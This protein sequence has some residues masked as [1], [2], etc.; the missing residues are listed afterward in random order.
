MR[1][2]KQQG[3]H[4]AHTASMW[5]AIGRWGKGREIRHVCGEERSPRVLANKRLVWYGGVV[6]TVG[7]DQHT[8]RYTALWTCINA[9]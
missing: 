1:Y 2:G 3:M 8:L 5:A 7:F 6:G 4:E 9:A